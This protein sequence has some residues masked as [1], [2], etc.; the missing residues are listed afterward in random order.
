MYYEPKNERD[1]WGD[2]FGMLWRFEAASDPDVEVMISRD[3]DSRLIPRE[4]AAVDEWLESDKGFHIMRDHPWH[5]YTILGGMWGAKKGTI[6][7]MTDLI[8]DFERKDTYGVDYDF[9]QNIVWP[10]VKDNCMIHDEFF[11]GNPFPTKREG[12][13]WVGPTVDIQDN[14]VPEH[15]E[16]LKQA[17][18]ES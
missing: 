15:V 1:E 10:R 3:V 14:P 2:W 18:N 9:C 12:L 17:L 6:P 13:E 8:K 4:K 5:K 7:E 11:E 16:A